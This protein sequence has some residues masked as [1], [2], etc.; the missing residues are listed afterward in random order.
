M[1]NRQMLLGCVGELIPPG[2]SCEVDV[3]LRIDN[4]IVVVQYT[5]AELFISF[6]SY[7]AIRKSSSHSPR[8]SSSAEVRVY[9]LTIDLQFKSRDFVHTFAVHVRVM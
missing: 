8:V 3:L 5:C 2:L 9:I 7:S 4:D 6:Q 1:L